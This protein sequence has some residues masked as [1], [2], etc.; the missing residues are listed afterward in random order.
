VSANYG[1]VVSGKVKLMWCKKCADTHH[2][3]EYVSKKQHPPPVFPYPSDTKLAGVSSSS[4]GEPLGRP[5]ETEDVKAANEAASSA[6]RLC[7][8]QFEH[9]RRWQSTAERA[10]KRLCVRAEQEDKHLF[11]SKFIVTTQGDIQKLS[12]PRHDDFIQ[13]QTLLR[14]VNNPPPLDDLANSS[15]I[16]M[17]YKTLMPELGYILSESLNR[18]KTFF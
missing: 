1:P 5:T 7:L 17:Y 2:K 3:H 15:D 11:D 13:L 14:L 8:E 6:R 18:T 4:N 10:R 9:K 16:N 12:K